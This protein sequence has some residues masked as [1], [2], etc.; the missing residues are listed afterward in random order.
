MSEKKKFH[1]G[2]FI[3]MSCFMIM[4]FYF[5][6]VMNCPGLFVIPVTEDL[7][8]TRSQYSINTTVISISMMLVA[9]F[10]GKIFGKFKIKKV[11]S[12]AAILLPITYAMYS[13]ATSITM[14]YGIS[15]IVGLCLGL[16]GMVP[17]STLLTRWFNEKRGLATGLA[18]TGSGVGGMILQP[19]IGQLIAN[20]GWRQTYLILGVLRFLVVVPCVIVFI[21]AYPDGKF[22]V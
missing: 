16:C 22:V 2:W 17:M 15:L 6:I 4:S 12:I 21:N 13:R 7:G 3:V 19:I 10:A 18:F 9:L 8:I 14:F 5:C 11:M 1:Y 20:V